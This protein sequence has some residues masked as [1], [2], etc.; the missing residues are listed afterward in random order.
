MDRTVVNGFSSAT[1]KKKQAFPEKVMDMLVTVSPSLKPSI[2][3]VKEELKKEPDEISLMLTNDNP[4]IALRRANKVVTTQEYMGLMKELVE[5]QNQVKINIKD[6]TDVY[7]V[8]LKV[9]NECAALLAVIPD[10][11]SLLA[12]HIDLCAILDDIEQIKIY[13]KQRDKR[14]D[15]ESEE[16]VQGQVKFFIGKSYM[17]LLQKISEIGELAEKN[18][19]I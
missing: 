6:E 16:F 18:Q 13:N 14:E 10:D 12:L 9:E 8:Y 15:K 5:K 7:K 1:M 17:E 11:E 4:I 3:D 19:W 2:A